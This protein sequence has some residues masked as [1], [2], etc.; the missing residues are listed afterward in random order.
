L[1]RK[2]RFE[3]QISIRKVNFRKY[4]FYELN[5]LLNF[6]KKIHLTFISKLWSYGN[7]KQA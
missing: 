5:W 7:Q 1:N 4:A 2:I 6:H 3:A